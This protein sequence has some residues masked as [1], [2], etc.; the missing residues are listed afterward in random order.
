MEPEAGK[1]MSWKELDGIENGM[2]DGERMTDRW[3]K[4][5]VSWAIVYFTDL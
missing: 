3:V 5:R 1:K 2:K 4:G